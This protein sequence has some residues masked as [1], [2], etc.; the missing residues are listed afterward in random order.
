MSK[1]CKKCG[2]ELNDDAKFCTSCGERME[3]EVV[4]R[5]NITGNSFPGISK[6][7]IPL[8]IILSIVTCTIYMLYW[9]VKL[10]DEMNKLLGKTNA[11]SGVM[12]LIYTAAFMLSIGFIKWDRML[13]RSRVKLVTR[14]FCI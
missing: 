3:Q 14:E 13:M 10:T 4:V 2:T 5:S 7:S 11:T 8:A 1:F 12:A 9:E 6:R